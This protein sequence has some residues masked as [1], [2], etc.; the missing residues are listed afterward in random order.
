MSK[1]DKKGKVHGKKGGLSKT[2]RDYGKGNTAK[3]EKI[4][5]PRPASDG[6]RLNKYIANSGICSR[7][8][9]DLYIQTGQVTVNSKVVNEMG[10]RV[11]PG[12]DVRCHQQHQAP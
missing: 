2:K 9:A 11:K 3:P 4:A 10:Y 8:E 1:Q 12:E 7:R 6:I 5:K